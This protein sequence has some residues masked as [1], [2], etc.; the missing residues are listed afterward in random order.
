[1]SASSCA[2]ELSV[3]WRLE[4]TAHQCR[5]VFPVLEGVRHDIDVVRG[6]IVQ[7]E[8]LCQRQ[9]RET[10]VHLATAE[11]FFGAGENDLSI[12]DEANRAVLV[13]RRNSDNLHRH[14]PGLASRSVDRRSSTEYLTTIFPA[15]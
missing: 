1:M 8:E 14:G 2:R 4:G 6:E 10:R 11:T 13:Q 7:A 3:A 5:L 12:V 9:A 15:V